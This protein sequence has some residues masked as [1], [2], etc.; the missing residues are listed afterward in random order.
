[1]LN[2]SLKPQGLKKSLRLMAVIVSILMLSACGSKNMSGD[3]NY[4]KK[5]ASINLFT[6]V[7][8]ESAVAL[9]ETEAKALIKKYMAYS[10]GEYLKKL[11]FALSQSAAYAAKRPSDE[12]A[13]MRGNLRVKWSDLKRTNQVLRD[14]MSAI[15]KSPELLA[16]KFTWWRLGP[17]ASFT[18]YYEP[19]LNASRTKTKKYYYPIYKMPSDVRKGQGYHDRNAID[20]KGVLK[21]RGLEIAYVDSEV[22]AFFLQVQGSGRLLFPD[23]SYV[24]A[25]YAGKN[26]R[27]YVSLGRI[28]KERGLIPPDQVNM[29]TIKAYLAKHPDEVAELLDTNPS[30]VFFR[31]ASSGPVGAIGRPLTPMMSL[32]SSKDKYPYGSVFFSIVALPDADGN[33]TKPFYN[34]TLPQDAGG[35]IKGYR[36]DLFCGAGDNA[37]HNAGHI[38][39]TGATYLLLAK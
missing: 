14:N 23:G 36:L 6:P 2:L 3:A 15:Q 17:D 25:L 24:H 29:K 1:M 21:N 20:R 19:T 26:N 5:Q 30:Y 32:A 37:A 10:G 12:M 38:D 34:I 39:W 13:F 31:E 8:T 27:K 22:D 7:T 28:M 4:K 33:P 18:G 9:S 35:A 16:K 11:D